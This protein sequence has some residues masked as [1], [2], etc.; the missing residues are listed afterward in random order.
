MV[1]VDG[2]P[3][4]L[5]AVDAG[6][7]EA[8]G[9]GLPLLLV[10]AFT[11]PWF[12]PPL[13]ATH[14]AAVPD[15][16]DRARGVLADAEA[17]VRA[18]HP[19]LPV[20]SRLV[21]GGAADVLVDAS[22]RAALVVVG[23]RGE[24]GFA[25]L[26]A[27]SAAVQVATHA[28]CPVMVVRGLGDPQRPVVVGVDGSTESRHAVG[29]AFDVAA[30]RRVPL[31][32]L[33]AWPPD[34]AWPP[35]LASHGYEAPP[36]PDVVAGSLADHPDRYPDVPVRRRVVRGVAAGRALVDAS[37]DAGVVVVGSRGHGGFAG[38]LLGS[39]SQTLLHHSRCP[40]VVTRG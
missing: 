4:S 24:G 7:A 20:R 10:H 23:A 6:A 32:V 26:L 37:G 2:S 3:P 25:E 18:G 8:A 22:R 38:L 11:W 12:W 29:F 40:V 1:G 31:V 14:D 35:E 5:A 13:D 21:D 17:R 19:G 33:H 28:R 34:L 30:R 27:G 39:V 9:R 36:A 15:P 16:R